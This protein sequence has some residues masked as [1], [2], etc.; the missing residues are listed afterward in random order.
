MSI[1]SS[2]NVIQ[3]RN[4]ITTQAVPVLKI[5]QHPLDGRAGFGWEKRQIPY[6]AGSGFIGCSAGSLITTVTDLAGS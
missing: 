4:F 3:R 6:S 5:P 2:M 1:K